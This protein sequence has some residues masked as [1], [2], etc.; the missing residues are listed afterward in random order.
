[1]RRVTLALPL[2]LIAAAPI[3]KLGAVSANKAGPSRA[4]R[5]LKADVLR[6]MQRYA[7]AAYHCARLDRVQAQSLPK[8]FRVTSVVYR[9][10]GHW[11]AWSARVCGQRRGFLVAMW[12]SRRGGV[13]F[14]IEPQ[15]NSARL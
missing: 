5:R 15:R 14:T 8:R 13:D 6:G 7:T 4:D 2:L 1:M 10:G 9:R 11:E 12:P 3:D